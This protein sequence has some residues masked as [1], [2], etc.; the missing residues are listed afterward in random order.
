MVPGQRLDRLCA[1]IKFL[2]IIV[3]L[4]FAIKNSKLVCKMS[5]DSVPKNS[6][7][8]A[9]RVFKKLR[10]KTRDDYV[11]TP[12]GVVNAEQGLFV[13]YERAVGA[14]PINTLWSSLINRSL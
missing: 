11:I 5:R 1:K 8:I 14:S 13:K 4:H 10:V 2:K 9:N 3:L 6:A 12:S 7:S